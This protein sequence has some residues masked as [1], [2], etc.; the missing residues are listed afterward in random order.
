MTRP[1][2]P[3][4]TPHEWNIH[5]A[6]KNQREAVEDIA[7]K[8][9]ACYLPLMDRKPFPMLDDYDRHIAN[10]TVY[11]LEARGQ[12]MGYIILIPQKNGFLLLDNIAVDPK[13]QQCGYGR[14]LLDFAEEEAI[15]SGYSHIILYT[16]EV[17]RENIIWYTHHGYVITDQRVE[18][19]Y[20]R[21]YFSKTV[22]KGKADISDIPHS[23]EQ[24]PYST[25]MHKEE[26][27]GK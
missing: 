24:I 15:R 8:A 27:K 18:K 10:G 21:I 9:Y 7:R 20:K 22:Q 16:N 23:Q 13:A 2:V 4:C 5:K 1:T 12:V 3:S 25:E 19:G 14:S 17:M 6:G 26:L 11:V